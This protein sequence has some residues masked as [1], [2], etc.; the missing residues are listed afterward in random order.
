[1]LTQREWQH[2]R[3]VEPVAGGSMV[4]DRVRFVPRAV[5]FGPLFLSV[6]RLAFRLRHRNLRRLFAGTGAPSRG[7]ATV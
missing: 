2:E 4:T 5:V 1:M 7:V 6:F 3:V